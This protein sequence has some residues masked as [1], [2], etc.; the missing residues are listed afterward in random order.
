[1]QHRH[2][3]H[4]R[5]TLAAIDDVIARGRWADWAAL[6]SAMLA[7]AALGEKVARVCRPH[8]LDPY[9]QRYHFWMSYVQAHAAAVRLEHA[10]DTPPVPTPCAT[11][12]RRW[13]SHLSIWM[14]RGHGR[15]VMTEPYLPD[16]PPPL[17]SAAS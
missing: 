9:A 15:A 1:M 5:L 2:L 4:Q 13:A 12:W 16:N 8:L 7:D 10:G 11:S 3:K 17:E 14:M 6:R